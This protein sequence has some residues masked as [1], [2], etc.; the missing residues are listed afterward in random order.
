MD[1]NRFAFKMFLH[2]LGLVLAVLA[3]V[4][5]WNL[6]T[7]S[8]DS[9]TDAASAGIGGALIM[10]TIGVM[11]GAVQDMRETLVIKNS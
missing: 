1:T 2:A 7:R 8:V 3:G 9:L 4:S 6:L 10:I 11:V 5:G